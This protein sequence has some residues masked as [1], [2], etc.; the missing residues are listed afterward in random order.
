MRTSTVSRYALRLTFGQVSSETYIHPTF[1]YLI[2]TYETNL[3]TNGTDFK[4][5][6]FRNEPIP[7]NYSATGKTGTRSNTFKY[8]ERDRIKTTQQSVFELVHFISNF[9]NQQSVSQFLFILSL[10]SQ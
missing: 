4:L 10:V 7:M 5:V 9:C 2:P 3:K 8:I 6:S 1:Q